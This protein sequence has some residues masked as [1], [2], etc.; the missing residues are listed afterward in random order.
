MNVLVKNTAKKSIGQVE[1][2]KSMG[3]KLIRQAQ[4]IKR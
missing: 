3:K 4:V 1:C 2:I